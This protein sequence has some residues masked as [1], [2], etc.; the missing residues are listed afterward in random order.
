MTRWKPAD[1]HHFKD[2]MRWLNGVARPNGHQR[3]AQN[4]DLRRR[5]RGEDDSRRLAAEP[6]MALL[7]RI[8][9]ATRARAAARRQEEVERLEGFISGHLS[10]GAVHCLSGHPRILA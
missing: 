9:L 8:M 3:V 2:G 7:S 5:H 10:A 1:S 6:R 4:R